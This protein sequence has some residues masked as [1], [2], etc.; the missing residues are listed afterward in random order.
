M[1]LRWKRSSKRAISILAA[2][3][4]AATASLAG[5]KSTEDKTTTKN[6]SKTESKTEDSKEGFTFWLAI[7]PE[8]AKDYTDHNDQPGVKY[9][10]E[11]TKVPVDYINPPV[12]SEK[13]QFNL[14][15]AKPKTMPN[16]IKYNISKTYPGGIGAAVEDGLVQDCTELIKENAP[17][18]MKIL[19]SNEAIRRDAYDDEGIIIRFGGTVPCA[20]MRGQAF[21]GPMIN[22][23]YLDK[24]N[25]KPPTT[26]AEW[27][28]CLQAFKEMGV[29]PFSFGSNNALQ[30]NNNEF[31]GAFGVPLGSKFMQI[32]GKVKFGPMEQGYK[33]FVELFRKWYA[34]GWLDP[35]FLTKKGNDVRTE[36][37]N[38]KVASSLLHAVIINSAKTTS[39]QLGIEPVQAIGVPYPVLNKGDVPHFK[40]VIPN[41]DNEMHISSTAKNPVE[42]IKWLDWFYSEEG[43]TAT[44]WGIDKD[45]PYADKYEPTYY[46]DKDGKKHFTDLMAKNPDGLSLD[47]AGR[48]YLF[49]D[50]SICWDWEQQSTTY[51][52]ETTKAALKTWNTGVDNAWGMPLTLALTQEESNDFTKSFTEITTYVNEMTTK[53]IVGTESMDHYDT[54]LETLKNMGIQKLIDIQQAAMDR[55]LA[56]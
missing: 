34:N 3:M 20:E 5:C 48:K 15:I 44:T 25:L 12:G 6:D 45:G 40:A 33:Q 22:K 17:N 46:T 23:T 7:H 14:M 43:K 52:D 11:L 37:E 53:F 55:Y 36:F 29:I 42:I 28:T 24:A 1:H 49:R 9:V 10:D 13:E 56:R 18:F 27:E 39:K 38:G 35:D 30:G 21:S 19:N 2:I 51:A 16:L 50:M 26:I 32:D 41:I 4:I 8:T 47:Q 31:A 54:F